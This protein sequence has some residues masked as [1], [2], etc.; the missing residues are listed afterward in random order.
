MGKFRR[1][2]FGGRLLVVAT[3]VEPELAGS[4]R[5]IDRALRL[6]ENGTHALRQKLLARRLAPT[7]P[8]EE[9]TPT[10][11]DEPGLTADD[12]RQRSSK[13]RSNQQG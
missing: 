10:K 1:P 12:L 8:R 7:L 11:T 9:W 13:I 3:T 4:A 2:T 6:L 5:A